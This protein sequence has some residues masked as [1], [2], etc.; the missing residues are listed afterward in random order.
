L[1]QKVRAMES[2]QNRRIPAVALT[3]YARPEDRAHAL[4]AGYQAHVP[5]P[6]EPAEL[7]VMVAT[8]AKGFNG[9]G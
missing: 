6:V 7:E 1:I 4:Q 9:H 5:K 2:G 3:A 8:L